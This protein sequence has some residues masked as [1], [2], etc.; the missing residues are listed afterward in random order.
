MIDNK[1]KELSQ[2]QEAERMYCGERLSARIIA[3]K[4]NC[5]I[6][7]IYKW[8]DKYNWGK[9]GILFTSEEIYTILQDICLI[10]D[11]DL[12]VSLNNRFTQNKYRYFSQTDIINIL[13]D[14][15]LIKDDSLRTRLAERIKS[16]QPK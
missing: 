7:T 12:R 10:K 13:S 1:P 8:R 16:N 5:N 11:N 4:I 14:I 3:A 9:N 2:I 15:C 6:K